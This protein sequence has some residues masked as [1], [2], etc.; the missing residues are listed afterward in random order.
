MYVEAGLVLT[1]AWIVLSSMWFASLL[2]VGRVEAFLYVSPTL[3][4]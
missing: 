1:N 4:R 2:H 3:G